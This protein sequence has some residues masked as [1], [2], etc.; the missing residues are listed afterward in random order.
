MIR[1]L[2]TITVRIAAG[3]NVAVAGGV[4]VTGYS[5]FFNPLDHPV[6]SSSG[7]VFPFFVLAD[8]AFLLFWLVFK[9]RL[10]LLP[11]V[12]CVAAFPSIRIYMPLNVRSAE[13]EG[14]TL[15]VLSYNVQSFTGA[16]RYTGSF[17]LICQYLTDS[18]ADIICIQ[19]CTNKWRE[20]FNRSGEAYEYG[21]TLCVGSGMNNC[22]AL[23][24]RFPIVRKEKIDYASKGNGSA[25]FF[26]QVGS[27]T[28]L[29]INNHFETNSFSFEEK[30]R[31]KTMLKGEM[32]QDTARAES[33][34][35]VRKLS[36]AI[37]KR[38]PQADAVHRYIDD[39]SQYTMIVCGDFNDTPLSY[40]RRIVADGLTDCFVAAGNGLGISY[41]LN[42]F[43]VR[44]DHILCSKDLAPCRCEVD[45]SIDASDHFPIICQLKKADK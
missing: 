9:K 20:F 40:T 18:G 22:I 21:D 14:E 19:E 26:L 13:T 38:A 39:H 27:D 37:M 5:S 32:E 23:F 45:D 24:S 42:G 1:Q 35:I 17:D 3:A 29:V 4:L 33:K 7:I 44:I 28:L 31:Y 6:L 41:N 12:G 8:I 30:R 34:R 43:F 10:A 25:A 11:I 15:T 36:E 16:P 2:K